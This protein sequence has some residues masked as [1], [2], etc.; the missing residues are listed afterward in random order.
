[1]DP[2][3]KR[4]LVWPQTRQPLRWREKEEKGSTHRPEPI[5]CIPNPRLR[6]IVH[7]D[8]V[9]GIA[10]LGACPRKGCESKKCDEDIVPECDDYSFENPNWGPVEWV[11]VS[12][13]DTNF[14]VVPRKD[15]DW[16]R[17]EWTDTETGT[18]FEV[19]SDIESK[20]GANLCAGNFGMKAKFLGEDDEGVWVQYFAIWYPESL[21]FAPVKRP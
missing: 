13:A 20:L 10:V 9:Y 17:L 16:Y 14:K 18:A 5:E 15:G 12:L 7:S 8:L 6:N 1:M 11:Q 19:R 21:G 4:H 2:S 3:A